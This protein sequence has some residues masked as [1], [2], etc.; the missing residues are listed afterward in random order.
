M[1]DLF[2]TGGERFAA[3]L[4][5]RAPLEGISGARFRFFFLALNICRPWRALN[6]CHLFDFNPESWQPEPPYLLQTGI[7]PRDCIL[8]GDSI[9]AIQI[10]GRAALLES[11]PRDARQAAI[12]ISNLRT[13]D[14]AADNCLHDRVPIMPRP[15]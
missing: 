7:H 6:F 11:L 13:N 2:L 8:S 9:C 14:V 15:A 3:R 4:H 12:V 5:A 10:D 1:A